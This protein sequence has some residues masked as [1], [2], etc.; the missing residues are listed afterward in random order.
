MGCEERFAEPVTEPVE[1][2]LLL[3]GDEEAMLANYFQKLPAAR[4]RMYAACTGEFPLRM[5][6]CSRFVKSAPCSAWSLKPSKQ[7]LWIARDEPP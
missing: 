2:R 7:F 3:G 1:S 5:Y 4:P 6:E